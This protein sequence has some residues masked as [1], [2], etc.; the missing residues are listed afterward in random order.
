LKCGNNLPG[1]QRTQLG[2]VSHQSSDA[3]RNDRLV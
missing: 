2:K 1:G 3:D